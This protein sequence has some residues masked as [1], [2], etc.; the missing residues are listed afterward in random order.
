MSDLVF[1][2]AVELAQMI[3][4][5]HISAVELLEAHLKQIA[6]HNSPWM[7]KTLVLAPNKQM[8]HWRE[9]RIGVRCMAFL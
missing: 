5:R 1:K 8:K 6:Q 4:D 9:V 7:R 3:R 2:S